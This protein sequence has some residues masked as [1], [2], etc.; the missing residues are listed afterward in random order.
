M[1]S[2]LHHLHFLAAP[3]LPALLLCACTFSPDRNKPKQDWPDASTPAG[4]DQYNGGIIADIT[5]NGIKYNV[6]TPNFA[7]K[8]KKWQGNENG[9]VQTM[10][11]GQAVTAIQKSVIFAYDTHGW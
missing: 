7:A 1:K 8:M 6:V 11:E 5:I 4:F 2:L 10:Y 3:A 9:F